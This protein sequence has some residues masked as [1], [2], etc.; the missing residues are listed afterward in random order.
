MFRALPIAC[1]L[2]ALSA[3][4][5]RAH[6]GEGYR[7]E[8]SY[9]A[10]G[11]SGEGPDAGYA[12]SGFD[13]RTLDDD[14]HGGFLR[15]EHG[16][17]GF[18]DFAGP[19]SDDVLA[20]DVGYTF[21]GPLLGSWSDGLLGFLELGLTGWQSMLDPRVQAFFGEGRRYGVGFALGMAM[22][23]TVGP[24]RVGVALHRRDVPFFVADTT[25]Y[26]SSTTLQLRVSGHL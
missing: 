23:G 14:G 3:S 21:G 19:P 15:V 4:A 20:L 16:T 13:L 1:A 24:F 22:E 26:M 9:V 8:G 12:A 2:I 18:F 10:V 5:A 11:R 6:A 25:G 17:P 7:S